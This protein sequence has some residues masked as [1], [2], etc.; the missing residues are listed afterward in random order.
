MSV[1]RNELLPSFSLPGLQ[2]QTVAGPEHGLRTLEM[3]VQHIA[4]GTG[5]PVHRHNCEEVI[6]V[7]RGSGRLHLS[8]EELDF[9]ANST[10]QIPPDAVHQIINTGS[11]EMFLVAALGQA[12]V[13][14]YTAD[15]QPIPLPWQQ[16]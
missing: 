10:L 6:L 3:W 2:H 7:L 12:P 8:G 13:R 1:I 14:V 16:A 9:S 15:R 5:T 11:E 4:P